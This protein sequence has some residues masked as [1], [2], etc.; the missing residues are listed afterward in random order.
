MSSKPVVCIKIGGSTIDTPGLLSE[1]AQSIKAIQ[2]SS[3]PVLVHGGGKDIG[4]QLDLLKKE[5]TFVEGMRVTDE[6]T[7]KHVQMVLSGDV[8]K[9]IINVFLSNGVPSIG[10]SGVDLGL[11]EA[12]RMTIKGQDIGFVGEV[13]KVD[14]RIISLCRDNGIVPVVSPVSRGAGGEFYNVNADLAASEIAIAIKADHLIYISDVPGVLIDR[15]VKHEI[16]TDEI[17]PL[18][19]QGQVTGGMIPKLRSAAD[20]IKRGVKRLH[21]CGWHGAETII[22][23]LSPASATGTVVF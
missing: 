18:I 23:E 20:A 6:Q 21:I 4:R 11:I 15:K 19:A 13:S 12:S 2:P 1:L 16:R 7:M 5:F 22:S 9:R 8:N 17:E 10:I 3:S 14:P